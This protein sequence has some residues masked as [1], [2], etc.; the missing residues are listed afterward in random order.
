M[1]TTDSLLKPIPVETI[2]GSENVSGSEYSTSDSSVKFGSQYRA[3]SAEAFE[4][5]RRSAMTSMVVSLGLIKIMSELIMNERQ[6]LR[7]HHIDEFLSALE[8]LHLHACSLNDDRKLRKRLSNFNFMSFPTDPAR[9]PDLVDQEIDSLTCL[10]R[11][12]LRIYADLNDA[13]KSSHG[14]DTADMPAFAESWIWRYVASYSPVF[15][16]V[17]F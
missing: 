14:R 6:C 1:F 17:F 9:L 3:G 4:S 15:L 8:G 16:L 2:L 7:L 13:G 11:L 5:I 10:V 12:T